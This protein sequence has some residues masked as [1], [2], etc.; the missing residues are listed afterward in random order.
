M[1]L[2]VARREVARFGE[3]ERPQRADP[4]NADRRAAHRRESTQLVADCTPPD[5][6]TLNLTQPATVYVAFDPRGENVWWPEWLNTFTRTG[7]SV[8]TTDQR[9]TVFKRDVPAGQLALGPNSGVPTKGN[10]TYI[11]FVTPR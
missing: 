4:F 5:Y 6:L 8:G 7:W 1:A 3:R 10:S 11:T 9:L 2:G